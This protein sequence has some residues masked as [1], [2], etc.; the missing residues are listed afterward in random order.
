MPPVVSGAGRT[1]SSSRPGYNV[2][3]VEVETVLLEQPGVAEAAVVAEP[4][5]SRGAVVRA[6]IVP[7]AEASPPEV[8]VPQLQE[9]VRRR[10]GRHSYPRI[11]DFAEG[12]PRTEPGKLRRSALRG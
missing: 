10:I 6:V 9:A 7:T 12:L 4:D 3:P 2:G 11:V 1:T 5:R 8:Q